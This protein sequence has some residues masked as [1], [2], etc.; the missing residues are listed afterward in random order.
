[1][2]ITW[3]IV[4]VAISYRYLIYGIFCDL[5]IYLIKIVLFET[6]HLPIS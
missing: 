3:P 6:W 4:G 1:M 5:L 2:A